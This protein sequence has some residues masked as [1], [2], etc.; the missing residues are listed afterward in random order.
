MIHAR[1][2]DVHVCT[3]ICTHAQVYVPS[4]LQRIFPTQES[5][6]GLLP[7]RWILYLLSY[8]GSPK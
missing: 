3:Y 7:H 2:T 1:Y 4:L 6:Q 5:N 8:Q